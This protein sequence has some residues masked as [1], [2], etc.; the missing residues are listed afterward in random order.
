VNITKI[1]QILKSKFSTV[2][3]LADS[4]FKCQKIEENSPYSIFYFDTKNEIPDSLNAL[5]SY[6]DKFIAEQYYAQQNDLRWNSYLIFVLS[7]DKYDEASHSGLRASIEQDKIYTRKHLIMEEEIEDFSDFFKD[8]YSPQGTSIDLSSTWI[9]LLEESGL[10]DIL[11]KKR[12]SIVIESILS[13]TTPPAGVD[14]GTGFGNEDDV[15][16]GFI[17]NL[18]LD[19]YDAFP[20]IP[21]YD[22]L[23]VNLIFGKNGS[24]K[25]SL[26][27]AIEYCICG[28]TR[29]ERSLDN[30]VTIKYRGSDEV[31]ISEPG[32]H[33]KFRF[34]DLRWYGRTILRSSDLVTS[35]NRY[36]FYN[37][38]A[39]FLLGE[40][41]S[42][43][44]LID[45]FSSL[46]FGEKT[47][48][49]QRKVEKYQTDFEKEVSSGR[50]FIDLLKK[51]LE[52][53]RQEIELK[54]KLASLLS[55]SV[56]DLKTFLSNK[57]FIRGNLQS[58][59]E[60]IDNIKTQVTDFNDQLKNIK[61]KIFWLDEI[62]IE[63]ITA[64]ERKLR[65]N[66]SKM[67]GLVK[68]YDEI[69][70]HIVQAKKDLSHLERKV[71]L[72]KNAEMLAEEEDLSAIQSLDS[73]RK[74]FQNKLKVI[75]EAYEVFSN[76]DYQQLTDLNLINSISDLTEESRQKL[77]SG[78]KNL[79]LKK[80][81]LKNAKE[82]ADQ[83]SSLI[84]E[85]QVL[86]NQLVTQKKELS[87]CPLCGQHYKE[88][89][90]VLTTK[91]DDNVALK[92][93]QQLEKTVKT[94]EAENK[95]IS[96]QQQILISRGCPVII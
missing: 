26:L 80:I 75:G 43:G 64:S 21:N 20:K 14:M 72:L 19:K 69:R 22:F 70:L 45:A 39:A 96:R 9:S 95:K 33:S 11:S 67:K 2:D 60:N 89:L 57:S 73:N 44:D 93:I 76:N 56:A 78:T 46:A 23:D 35:F 30:L 4:F 52:E 7:K 88:G 40:K 13:G 81:D 82:K 36:N 16:S 54:D 31:E 53:S 3:P 50:E 24:G 15:H 55:N 61:R 49:I 6:Q 65:G 34:R 85:I 38:D 63:N 37:T 90:K 66:L 94:I 74:L 86:A 77:D 58:K 83:I 42:E 79:A 71:N 10:A 18:T 25:S 28:E 68:K 48:V 12:K 92:T 51:Q 47:N 87:D 41:K 17:S 29:R 91:S 59:G 32:N 5:K 84:I 27:E 62:T 1:E 8:Q